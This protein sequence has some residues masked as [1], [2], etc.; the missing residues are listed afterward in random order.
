MF[1]LMQKLTRNPDKLEVLGTGEQI[2]DYSYVSDTVEAFILATEKEVNSR[3][4][5]VAGGNAISIKELAE[6]IV[7]I[8]GLEGKT[9][10]RFSGESWQGDILKWI[11][12]TSKIERELGFKPKV[13]LNAGLLKFYDWFKAGFASK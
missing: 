3:V 11:A 6:M 5:N 1:D 12:D 7:R 13:G 4:F 10:I 9:E 8:S 2:R